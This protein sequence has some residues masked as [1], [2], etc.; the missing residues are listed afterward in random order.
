MFGAVRKRITALAADAYAVV[1]LGSMQ[2]KLIRQI[3]KHERM[4]QA[5]LARATASDPTL[6]GRALA[7]LIERGLVRRKRS[8][9]DRREYVLEL[10][11]AGK[12]SRDQV[13]RLRGKLAGRIGEALDDRDLEDFER[14]A[15]K[16]LV[17]LDT[18]FEPS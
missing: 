17:A 9:E 5:E 11:A 2:A 7:T 13:E 12:R 4:S 14:I 10:S 15:N 1:D 8:D 6:T 16:L 18:P 3:G